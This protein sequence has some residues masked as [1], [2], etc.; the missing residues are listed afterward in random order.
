M[1]KK[2]LNPTPV[3]AQSILNAFGRKE[4]V[5]A[6]RTPA[7]HVEPNAKSDEAAK[8]ETV[9]KPRLWLCLEE[10]ARKATARLVI[11]PTKAKALARFRKMEG[12][13]GWGS[14]EVT[15]IKDVDG[16][17]IVLHPKK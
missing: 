7:R 1:A 15:E 9:D 13:L 4:P 5:Q 8:K 2:N 11:A 12:V 17:Q 14:Y 16:Y 6:P 10:N 3:V